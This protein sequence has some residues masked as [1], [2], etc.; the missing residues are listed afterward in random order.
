M[1]R[2]R[3][4]FWSDSEQLRKANETI[5]KLVNKISKCEAEYDGLR[6]ELATK[7]RRANDSDDLI[8][9]QIAEIA[10]LKKEIKR[11]NHAVHGKDCKIE[12]LERLQ[13]KEAIE[14]NNDILA[15]QRKID[16]LRCQNDDLTVERGV[17][18]RRALKAEDELAELKKGECP[19]A[20]DLQE[21]LVELQMAYDQVIKTNQELTATIR[22]KDEVIEKSQKPIPRAM[23]SQLLVDLKMA[24]IADLQ[25]RNNDLTKALNTAE[26]FATEY[27]REAVELRKEVARLRYQS[28]EWQKRNHE[29]VSKLTTQV[30]ST[31]ECQDPLA[32]YMQRVGGAVKTQMPISNKPGREKFIIELMVNQD[33]GF[34]AD[35][36]N[37]ANIVERAFPVDRQAKA[38]LMYQ[39]S[40]HLLPKHEVDHLVSEMKKKIDSMNA[41]Q[42]ELVEQL[43]F[44]ATMGDEGCRETIL[45]AT[46]QLSARL[47]RDAK[48]GKIGLSLT[49]DALLAPGQVADGSYHKNLR[50][51][52][53]SVLDVGE[54]GTE[55]RQRDT[56]RIMGWAMDM[57]L[58]WGVGKPAED[59]EN[60]ED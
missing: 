46:R 13:A 48:S 34:E 9:K 50:L 55:L 23:E 12:Y 21:R 10:E 28:E 39:G 3:K 45:L 38:A 54:L 26:G 17:W 27:Q 4:Q 18:H 29:L 7:Q 30:W 32:T 40:A 31:A 6:L 11:L 52:I 60:T 49:S 8:A 19:G 35:A 47:K 2:R 56:Y 41:K 59:E 33:E 53:A 16:A 1:G 44:L 51:A 15:M 57:F 58:T 20:N 22:E 37:I 25:A 24:E 42:K 43:P 5:K 36:R 14:G